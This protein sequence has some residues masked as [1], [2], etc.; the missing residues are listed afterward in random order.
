MNEITHRLISQSGILEICKGDYSMI[1]SCLKKERNICDLLPLHFQNMNS[2]KAIV[3]S[4][5]KKDIF[6]FRTL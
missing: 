1:M 2:K 4:E 6:Y 5:R 3:Q